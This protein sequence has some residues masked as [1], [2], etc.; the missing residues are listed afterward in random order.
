MANG[1]QLTIDLLGIGAPANQPQAFTPRNS[2][3]DSS[4]IGTQSS[5]RTS[6]NSR[7]ALVP[8]QNG[9]T[10]SSS[11]LTQPAHSSTKQSLAPPGAVSSLGASAPDLGKKRYRNKDPYAIDFDDDEDEDLLT[12]LPN[13][14]KPKRQEESLIDFL[15]SVEP[16]SL[17][18]PKPIL[19]GS[20][21]GPTKGRKEQPNMG[22]K[23]ESSTL[24]KTDVRSKSQPTVSPT[25][26][27][28]RSN[29]ATGGSR[30]NG[31]PNRD[32]ILSTA[33]HRPGLNGTSQPMNP[34][35]MNAP[36]PTSNSAT[37]LPQMPNASSGA[38][39]IPVEFST[40]SG[41]FASSTDFTAANKPRPKIE[42]RSPG[43]A[44]GAG[45]AARLDAFH[46]DD[47]ADF[48]RSSGP[49]DVGAP[50]PVV[51][52]AAEDTSARKRSDGKRRFPW[53]KKTYLDMP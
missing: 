33:T 2:N 48:L 39:R 21:T 22:K 46:T 18:A 49:P 11:S 28:R 34:L 50:A 40:P 14:G 32:G 51:G 10:S 3:R 4:T 16:P 26:E 1:S 27:K 12:A 20:Q 37:A 5:A 31:T 23:T 47:L 15:N 35:S 8:Q 36:N 7:T 42:A 38:P 30:Q 43:V 17:N 19:N 13:A 41:S 52:R 24:K 45:S 29:S 25:E 6:A 9:T 44:K 53:Q